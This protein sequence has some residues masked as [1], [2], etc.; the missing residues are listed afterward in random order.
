MAEIELEKYDPAI[1]HLNQVIAKEKS[2]SDAYFYRGLAY[3]KE[4]TSDNYKHHRQLLKL[5]LADYNKAIELDPTSEESYFD[6]GEVKIAL[7]DYIGAIADFKKSIELE[8]KDLE[9]HYMKAMCNYH[10]GYEEVALKEMKEIV[11]IDPNYSDA[12]HFIGLYYYEMDQFEA[13]LAEFDKLISLESKHADSFYYRGLTKLDMNNI[14][15]ACADWN[16]AAKELDDKEALH[17]YKKHC[18]SK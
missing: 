7:H 2:Y 4:G 14:D 5:S 16:I 6:R 3:Y 15:G 17:M 13:A 18:P 11:E 10:Y 8:P 1:E 9:A 12:H